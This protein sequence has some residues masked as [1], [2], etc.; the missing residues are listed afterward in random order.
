MSF[1]IL[2]FILDLVT[3]T[4]LRSCRYWCSNSRDEETDSKGKELV[5]SHSFTIGPALVV[6]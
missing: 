6:P 3:T 1:Y 5:S 4:V 2:Y